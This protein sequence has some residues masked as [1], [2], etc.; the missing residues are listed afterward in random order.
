MLR[1]YSTQIQRQIHQHLLVP[2]MGKEVKD[3]L[4][5]L[6]SVV[7]VQRRQTE[8]PGFRKSEGVLHGLAGTHFANQDHIRR[9]A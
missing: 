1:H 8:M 9:L 4:Q 6:V 3:A 2:L 5:R 7:G